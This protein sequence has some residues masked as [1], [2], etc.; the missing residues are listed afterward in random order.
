M[1]NPPLTR[2]ER[3]NK[4]K[5]RHYFSKYGEKAQAVIQSLLDKYSDDGLLTIESMDVLKLDPVNKHGSPIEIIKA[6]G[7]KANYLEALVELEQELYKA[8]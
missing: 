1:N 8:A 6:F 2:K 3:A 4:V 5:K 7:G